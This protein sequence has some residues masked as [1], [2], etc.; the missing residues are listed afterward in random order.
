MPSRCQQNTPA[1]PTAQEARKGEQSWQG[2]RVRDTLDLE[3]ACSFWNGDQYETV[4][5][6][7]V[8]ETVWSN[9]KGGT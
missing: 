3:R 8:L 5:G 4:C 1:P 6:A 9:V 7:M 2:K